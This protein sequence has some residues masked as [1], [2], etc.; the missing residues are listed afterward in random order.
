VP[1]GLARFAAA[2]LLIT[3]LA[4]CSLVPHQVAPDPSPA[5]AHDT[6]GTGI[7]GT[8]EKVE[9]PTGT[10]E[11]ITMS[12][13]DPVYQYSTVHH[14][15]SSGW[16]VEEAT[17]GQKLVVDYL[18]KEFL[19]STALEGGDAEFH[20]WFAA[21]GK[22]YY[23][24][25][26]LGE[27][28]QNPGENKIILGNFG[29]N[30]LIPNLIHDGSP[31]V[32]EADLQVT[33]FTFLDTPELNGVEYGVQFNVAYRVDDAN[34]AALVGH[35]TGMTGEQV[36]TS[37]YATDKL[38]D[39]TGENVY[40]GTGYANVLVAKEPGGMKIVSF[41]SKADFDTRDFANQDAK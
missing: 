26:V 28:G 30:K 25:S 32:K 8:G 13:S 3:S 37:K 33:G 19:D 40:R 24:E 14:D 5:T 31:R 12:E 23:S 20:N 27:A 29:E 38:K 22:N 10:Y 34:G 6:V 36:L 35:Y 4:G 41:G 9:T 17:A 15:A 1:Y 2:G 16:T 11:K 7:V 39:G 21:T 18:T